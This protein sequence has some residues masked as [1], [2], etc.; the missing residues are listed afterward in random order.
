[1][2]GQNEPTSMLFG[3]LVSRPEPGVGGMKDLDSR[4][5]RALRPA[6]LTILGLTLLSLLALVA[7]Q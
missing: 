2:Y 4:A 6:T 1:M 7:A 5:G 3:A